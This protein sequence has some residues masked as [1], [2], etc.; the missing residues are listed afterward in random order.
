L[1]RFP[2]AS[3]SWMYFRD[4]HKRKILFNGVDTL[5][6]TTPSE[7]LIEEIWNAANS[8]DARDVVPQIDFPNQLAEE[9][10]MVTDRFSMAHSIEARVPFLDHTFVETAMQVPSDLRI[11]ALN[12]KQL[13]LD[14]VKHLLPEELI[15]ARKRGFVLPL[16]EWTRN[17][18]KEI[19]E[20]YLGPANL[21]KQGI[22]SRHLYDDIVVPHMKGV[23]NQTDKIWTLLMFQMWYE[24]FC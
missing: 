13:L 23:S 17:E 22:F 21:A 14:T 2:H 8:N 18:L 24:S 3:F 12:P 1:L 16:K 4:F 6:E 11:G 20:D 5:R 19:V 10:L 7:L 15:K 9:F